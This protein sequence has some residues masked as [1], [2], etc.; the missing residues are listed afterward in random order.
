MEKVDSRVKEMVDTQLRWAGFDPDL[1]TTDLPMRESAISALQTQR[2]YANTA[3][4][5]SGLAQASVTSMAQGV[6]KSDKQE[7]RFWIARRS[8]RLWP[9]P[10]GKREQL[11]DYLKP[12]LRLDDTF[13]QE[14]LEET[15]IVRTREPRN[16]NKDKYIVTF[17]TKQVR[18]TVKA[19][20]S[21]PANFRETAGMR[22][23]I[24]DHLQ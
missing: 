15:T 23:H 17:K 3:S 24:L 18:D 5:S 9:I 6:T 1:T 10:G 13:I 7:A 20:A 4:S 16:K 11:E 22:L 19:A 12:K 14:E 8:L 2:S 21:N